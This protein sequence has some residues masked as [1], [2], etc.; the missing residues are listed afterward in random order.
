MPA[1]IAIFSAPMLSQ[2]AFYYY[3]N[4]Y[5]ARRERRLLRADDCLT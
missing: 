3:Q 1:R 4:F 2:G 5:F